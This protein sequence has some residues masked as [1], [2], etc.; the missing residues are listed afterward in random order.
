MDV[1]GCLACDLTAG[2]RSLPG[3]A[4]LTTQHWRVEHCV[5][6][7]G[8]GTLLVKPLRHVTRVSEL[9]DG[10]AAEQGPLL[11]RCASVVDELLVPAQTYVC[12]WSHAAGE[13][14]HIHYV[15]QP[16]TIDQMAGGS[17]YGPRLQS[18]MFAAGRRPSDEEIRRF[19]DR[20][21]A[22]IVR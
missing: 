14:A 18:A 9:T 6:P 4:I 12:L 13:P 2:R 11:H 20:A 8:I 19:A 3:G 7:L 22:V 10:E 5:G 17:L 16:V 1:A 15:I 21:R